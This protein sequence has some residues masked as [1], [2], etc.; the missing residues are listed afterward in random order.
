MKVWAYKVFSFVLPMLVL[1]ASAGPAAA[2]KQLKYLP[3]AVKTTPTIPYVV[4][5]KLSPTMRANFALP[6][7]RPT[8]TPHV[9]RVVATQV[10]VA[11]QTPR[12]TN[13]R[14]PKPKY[15]PQQ[16]IAA[17]K[18]WTIDH[19][20]TS[21]RKGIAENGKI[22]TLTELRQRAKQGDAQAA[23]LAAELELGQT[24]MA[25][26]QS[27]PKDLP[28]HQELDALY[29]Q[30]R[31]QAANKPTDE[32]YQDLAAHIKGYGHYPMW[33]ESSL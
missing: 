9:E 21:P 3:K 19:P 32:L 1:L 14:G 5:P 25:A 16:L 24:I 29:N 17:L 26:L 7:V 15:T 22:L 11:I 28:E 12:Q 10:E 20:G 33:N 27:W 13:K 6:V 18:Q 2:Q 23:A 8:A 30:N 4:H 31:N